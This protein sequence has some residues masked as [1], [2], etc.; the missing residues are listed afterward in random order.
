MAINNPYIDKVKEHK[1]ILNNV[2]EI[3]EN[4]WNWNNYFWNENDLVLEIW[5]WLWNFFSKE[6]QKNPNLNFLWMEIKY[7]RLYICAEKALW[8]LNNYVHNWVRLRNID[9][10]ISK[11]KNSPLLQKRGAGGEVNFVLLKDFWENINKIFKI[12]EI[13]KTYI[14]FPDPWDKKKRWLKNRLLQTDFLNNLYLV[15]KKGWKAIIKTD[16]F[17][18]YEFVLEELKNTSWKIIKTSTDFEN[19]Q[20]FNNE[21][22]TEFQQLFRGQNI[23]INYI[24]LEK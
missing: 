2:E 17:P 7:K 6:V 8:N 11:E 20:E 21:E 10:K 22:T 19:E 16:H 18:Y 24:E 4:K 14:F 1:N 3:Y 23:K 15:T 9:E 13:S 5:T 12:N